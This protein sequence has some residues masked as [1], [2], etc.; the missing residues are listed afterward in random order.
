MFIAKYLYIYIYIT[1]FQG[2][3]RLRGSYSHIDMQIL[4]SFYFH[5]FW[6]VS[7]RETW[8]YWELLNTVLTCTIN[9]KQSS[10]YDFYVLKKVV[11]NKCNFDSWKFTVRLFCLRIYLLRLLQYYLNRLM[12]C[13]MPVYYCNSSLKWP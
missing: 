11:L 5:G 2:V 10:Y 6:I 4:C 3:W 13:C 8:N 12:L 9:E 1:C 7:F